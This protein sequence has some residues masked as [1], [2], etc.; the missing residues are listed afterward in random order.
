M[1]VE[2]PD[3]TRCLPQSHRSPDVARDLPEGLLLWDGQQPI[4]FSLVETREAEVEIL[5]VQ[6]L[7]FNGEDAAVRRQLDLT[8]DDN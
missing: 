2:L 1:L 8:A 6:F 7:E 3:G 4:E 5:G